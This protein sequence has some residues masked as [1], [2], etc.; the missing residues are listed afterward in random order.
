MRHY[1]AHELADAWALLMQA[2]ALYP[3][4]GTLR[5]L[6]MVE[7]ERQ[8]YGESIQHLEA[9]LASTER[10]LSGELRASTDA[11]LARARTFI[12]R[13]ELFLVP[14]PSQ[15]RVLVDGL[16]VELPAD[17]ALTLPVGE[18]I[19]QVQ[20]PDCQEA[21]RTLS[22]KGGEAKRLIIE[23]SRHAQPS[24]AR[25]PDLATRTAPT[26]TP[27]RTLWSSPWFWAV[28]DAMVVGG[29][30]TTVVL[31]EPPTAAKKPVPGDVGVGGLVQAL[32]WR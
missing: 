14:E 30:L 32:S 5:G 29:V 12:A 4:A 6:G 16:P 25:A 18:H 17:H 15:V 22:V 21:K 10:P 9:A 11:L 24:A 20:A 7:L 3:N 13:F 23:L 31:L 8:N 1:D 26:Q 28:V 27:R 19:L 2:H